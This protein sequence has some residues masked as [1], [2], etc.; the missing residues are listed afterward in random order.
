M[1]KTRIVLLGLAANLT[2]LA[3]L[4]APTQAAQQIEEFTTTTSSS[5]AGDHP[6]L[7]TSFKLKEAGTPEVAKN[8][9]FDAPSGLYG[10]PSAVIQCRAVDFALQRC[11]PD[12]QVGLITVRA[13]YAGEPD[14]LLGTAPL[15]SVDPGPDE[16]ARFSFYAPILEIPIAIP[17]SVRSATDYGLRFTV[18]GITQLSPLASADIVFWGI[19]ALDIH[20]PERFPKGSPGSPAGCPGLADTSCISSPVSTTLSVRPLISN[21]GNCDGEELKTTLTVQTYQDPSHLSHAESSYPPLAECLR[22]T[23]NPSVKAK[24]TTAEADSPSG[25]ELEIGAKQTQGKGASPANIRSST[26][27]LPNELTI[28]PD[29]A[30]GQSACTDVQAGFGVEGAANCPDNSKVGTVRISSEGL[31]G[32]IFGSIYFGEPVPGNQYRLFL[33]A[34]GYGIHAKLI[35]KLL[36]D[37]QTGQI[38]ARF[39]DLPQLP[40][41]TFVFRLFA[42]DRGVLATPTRCAIYSA[43][44]NLAPWNTLLADQT[45]SL[46]LGIDSGPGGSPC[47]GGSRPFNPRLNAGTSNPE[48]GAYSSFTL[49][50]DRDDG[51]QY[52]GKLDFTMPPGLT[53]NLRGITYC[54]EAS[55]VAAAN[56]LGRAQQAS[57][58]CPT[59]SAIGT[60]NVAAG[61]GSHPFHA[62]GK[63]FLA[64]PFKGA[65]L[66]LA[67]V[68]P[69]LAGP[70]D[71]GTVV[72]RVALHIDKTD[73]HVIAD[74]E[75]V[76]S[77]IG[78]VPL[79]MRS[80]EVNID[81]P[82][83]MI[84]PTNCT[85]K[86]VASRGIGDQ[87]AVADF[88]SPF[89]TVNCATLPF[90]PRMT[91]TQLDRK[92]TAR[93]KD[94]SL[95][96][97]LRTRSGDAN[98][99]SVAVTLPKTFEIDQRHLGNLC[100]R[101]QLASERCAGRAAIGTV[102]TETPLLEKPLEGPAYAV[103]GFGK[104]P[105]LVFILGGQVTLMPEAISSSVKGRL[106]TVVPTVP[107]A[108]IGHFTLSLFG[109]KRGYLTNTRSLCYAPVVSTI[110][111]TAQN[112]KTM[113]K[114]V[115]AK[116]ACGSGKAKQKRGR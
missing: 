69:A 76:P 28:N 64:G 47:P 85:P 25:L 101:A 35:G 21:P 87:G 107:D 23:F 15:Y 68:T 79:R 111:Y 2:M 43:K 40:F 97:D 41:D 5:L 29:A 27:V 53:A 33:F 82:N 42:S 34:D 98:I 50:L 36:P 115:T 65:P 109:G 75:T 94:P 88:S 55:I 6:E 3:A 58:S 81:K 18:S 61:P 91:V 112:G 67:V 30:D 71:Y 46:G 32:D 24:L 22:Q 86:T 16:A 100:S 113:S 48:G 73:A 7:R 104:L 59:S 102:R 4:A 13:R 106:R 45:S 20:N 62:T 8:I 93:G 89:T 38:T 51:D 54:P 63:V 11:A 74:S 52:L 108:P 26:L 1:R 103:S 116:T 10:N 78:G 57:P 96:F 105:H 31:P 99:K 70:F 14:Y 66:S 72:V 83:F 49:K 39:D 110:E 95:R 44:T 84:N 92:A 90:K 37:P 19:P 9:S 60:S 114:R 77:I 56:S 12:A 80:I 17:V